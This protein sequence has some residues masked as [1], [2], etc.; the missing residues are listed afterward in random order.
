MTPFQSAHEAEFAATLDVVAD[1]LVVGSGFAGLTAALTARR[2]GATVHVIEKMKGLGGNSVISD[3][4][5][6]AA[7]TSFQKRQGIEDSPESMLRD[8][9]RAGRGLSHEPLARAV[10][11]G[12]A[13]AFE[14]LLELGVAFQ[15]KVERSGGHAA[16]RGHV[17]GKHTGA[18]I[19]HP[20]LRHCREEGVAIATQTVLDAFITNQSGRVVGLDV[21]EGHDYRDLDSGTPRRIGAA[22]AVV[23]ACGGFGADVAFRSVQD[24]RLDA[25][26]DTTNKP[27]ALAQG[28]VA[29][30]RLG[31]AP[32]Q[33]SRIQ[34][35]PWGSP[36]EKGFGTG[37]GFASYAAFPYG[38][39]VDPTTGKRFMNEL[40]DRKARSDAILALGHP[41]VSIADEMACEVASYDPAKALRRG[42]VRRFESTAELGAAYDMPVDALEQTIDSF[43][44]GV[45][46]GEDAAFGKSIL[47]DAQPPKPP[48]YAMRTWPKVHFT[49][50]GLRSDAEARVLDCDGRIIPGLYAAGE[51]VGG[52][53]GDSR[54]GSAAIAEC[55]VFGRIAGRAA[56]R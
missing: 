52:T 11:F 17:A 50:G 55:I 24:P 29:A 13:E 6:A 7:G 25:T 27:S 21:R 40:G 12:S 47:A 2:L 30:M 51:V 33:L 35:G 14:W 19:I 48:F 37:P 39:V 16:S 10:A 56:A 9:L 46:K 23:L 49:M 42:V 5:I 44:A 43:A 38:L 31:A 15:D 32:V 26:V 45:A 20:L 28:L 34:L 41:A 3:G 54:L 1:V 22:R 18:A 4:V 53:H 36:D 8:M